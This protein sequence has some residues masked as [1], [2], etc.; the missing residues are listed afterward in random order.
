MQIHINVPLTFQVDCIKT[1]AKA[2]YFDKRNLELLKINH[3]IFIYDILCDGLYI[4]IL[5][6][7][8]VWAVIDLYGQCGQVSITSGSGI[9]PTD[10]NT[11]NR[12]I[13]EHPNFNSPVSSAGK[14][15]L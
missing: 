9:M 15:E 8:G 3:C 6:I 7:T 2:R 10:N 12:T 4:I 5:L 11:I 1:N 13:V 14:H